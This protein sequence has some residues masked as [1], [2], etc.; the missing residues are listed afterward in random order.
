MIYLLSDEHGGERVGDLKK[1][2]DTATKNDILIILG[3]SGVKFSNTQE[4]CEFDKMLLS[5]KNQI[6][7][8]DGNHEN[9]NYLY[10]LPKEEWN[11][12]VVNRLTK[13]IVQLN[14]GYVF[15]IQGK[16]FFV[17]GGCKSS[18]KWKEQGVWYPEEEGSAEEFA[19]A[20]YSLKK[21]NYKV[22]YILMHKYETENTVDTK[23]YYNLCKFID[24]NVE[25]KHFYSGHWHFYKR[26][27]KKHTYVYGELVCVE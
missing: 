12:G 13:N 15:E 9:F 26:V 8:V 6:A 14:R 16:T 4:N 5:S 25:Y 19:R 24:D 18:Q 21:H 11:G 22:D 20:Y 17:F 10:S 23:E 2:I 1:Y 27:D 7:I 3:D